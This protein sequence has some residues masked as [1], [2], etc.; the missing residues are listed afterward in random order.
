V[1]CCCAVG[2]DVVRYR[3]NS[4][5][6]LGYRPP[7]HVDEIGLTSD[8]YVGLNASVAALPLKISYSPMSLQRWQL[9][10]VSSAGRL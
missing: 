3:D 5:I 2:A 7:L 8:K 6:R 10:K 4:G 1:V 9:M